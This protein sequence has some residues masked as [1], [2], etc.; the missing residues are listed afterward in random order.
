[1]CSR[2]MVAALLATTLI[3]GCD[4]QA[5]VLTNK[6]VDVGARTLGG[7]VATPAKISTDE[8]VDCGPPP[9]EDFHI[10]RPFEGQWVGPEGLLMIV[11]EGTSAPGKPACF[12][13]SNRWTLDDEQEFVLERDGQTMRF[14][15]N[16]EVFTVR[17]GTG[18]ETGFK[19]LAD[20]KQCLIVRPGKEGYCRDHG[21]IGYNWSPGQVVPE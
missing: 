17:Y 10:P 6:S 4:R 21:T 9:P 15:R 20:K 1:M 8:K 14:P 19:W 11:Q 13:V 16:G 7:A 2:P 18:E 3:V 12:R 5:D